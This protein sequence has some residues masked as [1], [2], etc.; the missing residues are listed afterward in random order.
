MQ[1]TP[2]L[3]NFLCL[4]NLSQKYDV[5]LFQQLC[6]FSSRALH[7]RTLETIRQPTASIAVQTLNSV[8]QADEDCKPY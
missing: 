6:I 8:R 5:S 7:F 3:Q 2:F 4:E 1:F